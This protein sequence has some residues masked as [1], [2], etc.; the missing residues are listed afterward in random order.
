M[1]VNRIFL[2]ACTIAVLSLSLSVSTLMMSEVY[3]AHQP[4]QI[5]IEDIV[6][7]ELR[8]GTTKMDIFIKGQDEVAA[9]VNLGYELNPKNDW[10][11]TQ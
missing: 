11:T 1:N 6:H 2:G 3:M 5:E 10:V 9:S 7:S 8:D 4:R